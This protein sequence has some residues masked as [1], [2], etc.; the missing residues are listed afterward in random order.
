MFV[1][2]RSI[3]EAAR[4]ALD[5][6][7]S[8]S[9]APEA[10]TAKPASH[11]KQPHP[12]KKGWKNTAAVKTLLQPANSDFASGA[13]L[14]AEGDDLS[15]PKKS[16]TFGSKKGAPSD[17]S[18]SVAVDEP[19][20]GVQSQASAGPEP[21]ADVLDDQGNFSKLSQKS[22]QVHTY[23]SSIKLHF[24]SPLMIPSLRVILISWCL[25]IASTPVCNITFP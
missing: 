19:G 23:P 3:Q 11:K 14:A 4:K 17:R 13:S 1:Q 10:G 6:L 22:C 9:G 2:A 24:N 20:W 25:M 12:P 5:V 7:P 18:G 21:D 15:Q 16:D 8:Q